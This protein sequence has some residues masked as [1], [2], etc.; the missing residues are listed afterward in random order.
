MYNNVGN[1]IKVLA[2]V[3][4][5]TC[6]AAGFI[7]WIALLAN[8]NPLGWAA[9]G[10]GIAMLISTWFLYGFGQLVQDVH[11]LKNNLPATT[12]TP[13]SKPTPQ[14]KPAVSDELPDL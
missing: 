9:L 4:G 8:E 3:T 10:G 7:A 13:V 12:V 6:F 5:W 14:S 11:E 2:Q 1:K